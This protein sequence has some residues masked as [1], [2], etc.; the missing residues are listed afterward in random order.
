MKQ[1]P[2]WWDH[3]APTSQLNSIAEPRSDVVIIG[4]GYTGLTAALVLARNGASVTVLDAGKIGEGASSRNGGMVGPSF[5]KLG[6]RGLTQEFGAEKTNEILRESVGFVDFL[7]QFLIEEN[8]DADFKQVGRFRGA[9]RLDHY[10]AMARELENLQKSCGVAGHMVS[11]AQQSEETGSDRFCGGVVYEQDGG[12]H[13]AKY[14]AGLVQKVKEA[15]VTL[16]SETPVLDVERSHGAYIIHTSRGTLAAAKVAVCT[17]GY[18]GKPFDDFQKRILP[19]RSALIATEELPADLI[20][21]LMPKRR[22]Y[23]DSRRIIAYYRTTPDGKR[24]LFGGRASGYRENIEQNIKILRSSMTDIFPQM[25]SVALSH[26]WSGLVAYT[27]DHTPHIGQLGGL[28]FAMGY[29]GSGVARS[30]YFGTKLGYKILGDAARGETAFD[31]IPLRKQFLYSGNPWFMPA[32]LA[33]HRLADK[34]GR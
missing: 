14:H 2:Y 15:G 23:G 7:K 29:C 10:D 30:S 16:I 18:T 8:I 21:Q 31:E 28:H 11:Q 13:P 32:V 12:L 22:M 26:A 6:V 20:D 4:S 5:H 33:W 9:M 1:A 24:M 19:L 25:H 17:N 3:A 34:L 27:F